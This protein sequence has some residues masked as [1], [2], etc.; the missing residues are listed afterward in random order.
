VEEFYFLDDACIM[1]QTSCDGP[2]IPDNFYNWISS[3]NRK[4]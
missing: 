2:V 1:Y 3:G 4:P